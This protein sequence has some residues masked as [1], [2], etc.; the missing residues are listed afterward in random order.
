MTSIV[1]IDKT[2][3]VKSATVKDVGPESLCK[4]AG[5]K[6]SEG[7]ALQHTWGQDDGLDKNVSLY[8][9]TTGRAGQENKYDFPPP[10]DE[11]LFFGTCVLVGVNADGT[12][13]ALTAEDWKEIYECL[14]GGFED[15]G[16]SD[17]EDEEDVATDDELEALVKEGAVVKQTAQGYVKDGFIVDDDEEDEDEDYV[18]SSSSESE[19]TPP[20][21]KGRKPS[22]SRKTPPAKRQTTKKGALPAASADVV[23]EA[24]TSKQEDLVLDD[25]ESELSEESYD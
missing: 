18:E 24:P 5:F 9:K 16:S 10:V 15:I 20:P 13:A 21:R 6:S 4:K 14:F 11:L 17:S 25:C 2:G 23:V 8:A 12:A 3:S 1:L 19:D 22:T 7:F